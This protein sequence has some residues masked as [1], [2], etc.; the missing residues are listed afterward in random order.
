V[1]PSWPEVE[2]VIGTQLERAFSDRVPLDE[3]LAEIRARADPLLRR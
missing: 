3:V 2:D 1:T